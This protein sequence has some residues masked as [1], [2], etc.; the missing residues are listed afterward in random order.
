MKKDNRLSVSAVGI[1]A[2]A[3]ICMVI[4]AGHLVHANT[5][6]CQTMNSGDNI[7]DGWGWEN[8]GTCIV[9]AS[10]TRVRNA[11]TL[12][13]APSLPTYNSTIQ[14]FEGTDVEPFEKTAVTAFEGTVIDLFENNAIERFDDTAIE[15]FG[16]SSITAF[17]NTIAPFEGTGIERFNN[18]PVEKF[19]GEKI[20]AFKDT[21]LIQR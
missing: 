11:G 17:E 5:P 6:I 20:D 10:S 7:G 13:S 12:I 9:Q 15:P 1:S 14:P 2:Q 8:G 19:D 16:D 18:T 3:A 4:L 21:V